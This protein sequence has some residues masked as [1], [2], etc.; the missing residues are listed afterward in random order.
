VVQASNSFRLATA[1][2]DGLHWILR[3]NCSV[4]PAQ[5]GLTFGLLSALSLSVALFFWFQGAVLVLP[6]A[7][8]ELMALATAFLV[9]ARHAAD[10]ERISVHGGRLVVELETAGRT[11]RCEFARDWVRVE[12]RNGHGLVELRAGGRSVRVGRYLRSDLRPVLA[13]EIRQ[14]LRMG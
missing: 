1:S 2:A 5:L 6:F 7:A 3:R 12:P 10:G 8:L 9:Y 4:S 14:A 13:R 11:E